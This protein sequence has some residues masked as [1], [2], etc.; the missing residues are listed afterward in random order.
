MVKSKVFVVLQILI[1]K[2][3]RRQQLIKKKTLT[4]E[5]LIQHSKKALLLKRSLLFDVDNEQQHL[6]N[7]KI[8]RFDLFPFCSAFGI[9][10]FLLFE[11]LKK[12]R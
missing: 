10:L 11:G 7:S 2:K 6:R 1:N 8:R 4:D 5:A 12:T 9:V 3:K